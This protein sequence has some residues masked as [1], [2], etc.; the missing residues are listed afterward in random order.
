M[1]EGNYVEGF[2]DNRS[3]DGNDNSSIYE[4]IELS[5]I[6]DNYDDI[7]G[8][9]LDQLL[10]YLPLL[11]ML[12][13]NKDKLLDLIVVDSKGIIPKYAVP[14]TPKTKSVYMSDLLSRLMAEFC[15]SKNLSQ[16]D[17]VEGSIIDYLKRH[18]YKQEV[19][20]LLSKR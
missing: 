17:V 10:R 9:E 3:M 18:G 19:D 1:E 12:G 4:D 13:D 14:G 20:K 16:R 11:K 15:T 8:G 5:N 2:S 7:S 6:N